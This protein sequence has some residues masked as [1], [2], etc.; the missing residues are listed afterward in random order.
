[1]KALIPLTPVTVIAWTL[2]WLRRTERKLCLGYILQRVR[3]LSSIWYTTSSKMYFSSLKTINQP[4]FQE[5][6]CFCIKTQVSR[7]TLFT[8]D[9][10]HHLWF[11]FSSSTFP[12]SF[13][14]E[15]VFWL[16]IFEVHLMTWV[17]I[18]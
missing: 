3:K 11:I 14:V 13:C 1:V 4:E 16:M 7:R 10:P 15:L 9:S 12:S 8:Y 6:L 17:S 5:I 2:Y 18:I